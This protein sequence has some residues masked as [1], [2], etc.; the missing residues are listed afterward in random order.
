MKIRRISCTCVSL[1]LLKLFAVAR[2]PRIFD[3]ESVNGNTDMTLYHTLQS[4]IKA[5]SSICFKQERQ[6]GLTPLHEAFRAGNIELALWL[7]KLC[8]QKQ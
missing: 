4:L 7:I 6:N 5:K 8:P 2:D 3:S 1:L